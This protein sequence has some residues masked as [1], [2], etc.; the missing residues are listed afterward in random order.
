MQKASMVREKEMIRDMLGY[1]PPY[2]A[3]YM[4]K[5]NVAE[6]AARNLPVNLTLSFDIWVKFKTFIYFSMLERYFLLNN[7]I[8]D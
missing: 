7:F 3:N 5:H 6:E 8:I 1:T 2:S 4:Q